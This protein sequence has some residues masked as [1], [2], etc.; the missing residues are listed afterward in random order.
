MKVPH[1][2]LSTDGAVSLP[3]S[4][5]LDSVGRCIYMYSKAITLKRTTF[6]FYALFT[7]CVFSVQF[8]R[9]KVTIKQ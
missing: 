5:H 1:T 8:S 2:E 3:D 6:T 7:P 9:I 4:L